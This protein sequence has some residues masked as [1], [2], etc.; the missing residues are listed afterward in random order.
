MVRHTLLFYIILLLA[1]LPMQF[2]LAQGNAPDSAAAKLIKKNLNEAKPTQFFSDPHLGNALLTEMGK[3]YKDRDYKMAWLEGN[4]VKPGVEQLQKS[5][6]EAWKDG[7]DK[8]RYDMKKIEALLK[9]AQAKGTDVQKMVQAD[10]NLTATYLSYGAHLK[11]GLLDPSRLDTNWVVEKPELNMAEHLERAL[12]N[13]SIEE[14]L[15][16]LTPPYK[17]YEHLKEAYIKHKELADKGGWPTVPRDQSQKSLKPGAT[18]KSITALR[19]RL[20][21]SGEYAGVDQ[22]LAEP[23]VYDEDLVKAVQK[24]QQRHGLEPDGTLGPQTLA[25]LNV[26]AENRANQLKLNMERMR[27]F[28]EDFAQNALVVNVPEYMLRVYEQGQQVME[29]RIVVGKEYRSTPMFNDTMEYLE[30]SPTWIVPPTIA[31]KDILPELKKDPS[32]AKKNNLTIYK[33]WDEGEKPLDPAKVNWKKIKADAFDYKIVQ[34]PGEKNPLGQVKFM[35][36]NDR[37]IYLHDT[38]ADHLF[39][40]AKRD[41]SSG[42][43]RVEKPVEL[44]DYLLPQHDRTAVEELMKETEPREVKVED[45]EVKVQIVYV[46]AWVDPAGQVHF[47]DDIYGHDKTQLAAI[48]KK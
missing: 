48:A 21:I 41:V 11:H 20:R 46:T 35:F 13:G 44:A 42:C 38:P 31:Q 8:D 29:M 22:A 43:I 28:P 17:A 4:K 14:S 34:E 33:S 15:A 3:F 36:P 7:L 6:G 39:D 10:L 23:Q 9:D 26:S 1:V 24:F 18:S 12:Q 16:R 19:D 5:L 25:A 30:F 47:R 40:Q 37:D 45:K 2:V 32:Y 27:W